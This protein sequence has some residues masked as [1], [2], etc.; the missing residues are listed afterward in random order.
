LEAKFRAACR[1]V[2]ADLI[3]MTALANDGGLR[4]V[5]PVEVL[6][7]LSAILEPMVGS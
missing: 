1:E 4:Y 3:E 2:N 6:A 5:I 7:E